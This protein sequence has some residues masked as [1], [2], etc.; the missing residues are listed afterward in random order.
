MR[1]KVAVI[2]NSIEFG[3]HYKRLLKLINSY[4]VSKL[5]LKIFLMDEVFKTIIHLRFSFL[6]LLIYYSYYI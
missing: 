4:K 5:R 3:L 6:Y 2:L 1:L